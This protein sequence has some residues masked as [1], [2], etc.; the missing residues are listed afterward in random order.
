MQSMQDRD[1][2]QLP[3]CYF[4]PPDSRQ[5]HSPPKQ[6]EG[7]RFISLLCTSTWTAGEYRYLLRSRAQVRSS[8]GLSYATP[9]LGDLLFSG[10]LVGI[11]YVVTWA[12]RERHQVG[13]LGALSCCLGHTIAAMQ[14]RA[15]QWSCTNRILYLRAGLSTEVNTI[16][17]TL[18]SLT[19]LREQM[20]PPRT[21]V[22]SPTW[23]ERLRCPSS[24]S[25]EAEKRLSWGHLCSK[26]HISENVRDHR[27]P[28]M[29]CF[30]CTKPR[31]YRFPALKIH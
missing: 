5:F 23:A 15:L 30:C 22:P 4:I 8:L 27:V 9:H 3:C 14:W 16:F 6:D 12:Q 31:A 19:K 20:R 21:H 18:P 25:P 24:L 17:F 13:K 2:F 1:D 28:T 29:L 10:V 11:A 7:S 26:R